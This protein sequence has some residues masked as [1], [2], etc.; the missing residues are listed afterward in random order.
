MFVGRVFWG[1]AALGL[2]F[3]LGASGVAA[4]SFVLG[5]GAAG[6][7]ALPDIQANERPDPAGQPT[8]VRLGFRLVDVTEIDDISQSITA[9]FLLVQIWTDPRMADFEGCNFN[10]DEIWT[11]NIDVINS[12][13]LF[14]RLREQVD[15]QE[16]GI[17]RY[18]QRFRGAL[19]FPYQ[20]HRFPFDQHDIVI[21]LLSLDYGEDD[22]V[23]TIDEKITGPGTR[24]FN[25]PDWTIVSA[26]AN[27]SQ[28]YV[29]VYDRTHTLFNFDILAKRISAYYVWKVIVPLILIVAM[30]WTVFWI[31]PAQFGPQ[32]GMSATSMLTLIA[33]Q[34]AMTSI[35]PRLSYFTIMDKF[36]TGST[37]LVFSAL[38]VSVVTSYLVSIERAARAHVID[39]H[40]RWVF[41]V[42]YFGMVGYVFWF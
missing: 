14:K 23:L 13:R 16:A 15:V 22:V 18:V 26:T 30:S 21:S 11:P 2:L 24:G 41:P 37:I 29:D 8:E 35:L 7:C 38:V 33:F 10:L 17:V 25:I 34:F 42:V 3:P 32:I 36:I 5:P 12:G 27:T 39:N 20:A 40:C 9:D 1:C 6:G 28:A 19:V 31:D 4:Q